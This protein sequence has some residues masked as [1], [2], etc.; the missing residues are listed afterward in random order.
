MTNGEKYKTKDEVPVDNKINDKVGKHNL[1]NDSTVLYR[2]TV[3]GRVGTVGRCCGLETREKVIK[4]GGAD[5]TK[6][7]VVCICG[8]TRFRSEM[9]DANRT[10]TMKGKI[11]LAPG[12]FGHAGDPITD[13]DKARLDNLHFKKIDMSDEVLVVNKDGYIGDS[14][15]REIDYARNHGKRVIYLFDSQIKEG[16]AE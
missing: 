4:E 5:T 1:S 13:D 7:I 14:T 10:E 16:G 2:C 8:S 12:V 11:V 15:R 9:I 3:C 6:P